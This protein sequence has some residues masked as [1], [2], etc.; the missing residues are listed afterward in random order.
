M[1]CEFKFCC[2]RKKETISILQPVPIPEHAFIQLVQA[3]AAC[4]SSELGRLSVDSSCTICDS[5][6]PGLTFMP[7]RT[8]CS[9]IRMHSLR[10]SSLCGYFSTD[11]VSKPFTGSYL[12]VETINSIRNTKSRTFTLMNKV[13]NTGCKYTQYS[14]KDSTD[15]IH[16]RQ[17]PA[18]TCQ[19]K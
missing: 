18:H 19:Q 8:S 4:D 2:P 11:R 5:S 12:L 10:L 16:L 14:W 3:V 9:T 7:S 17:N 13:H 1:L 15:I 6:N